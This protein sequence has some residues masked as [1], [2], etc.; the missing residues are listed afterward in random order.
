M[1]YTTVTLF[2]GPFDGECR[3]VPAEWPA[4]GAVLQSTPE[5]SMKTRFC[6]YL[7]NGRG[8]MVFDGY[9]HSLDAGLWRLNHGA[10]S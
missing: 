5:W 7:P 3:S 4:A 1:N 2:G 6:V 8:D 10:R 9:A